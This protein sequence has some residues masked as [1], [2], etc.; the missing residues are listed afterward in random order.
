M[1]TPKSFR[2]DFADF[3][4]VR[5]RL[6]EAKEILRNMED[7]LKIWKDLVSLMCKR[8]GEQSP[9]ASNG[10]G[11][12]MQGMVIDALTREGRPIKS[13]D[14]HKM[15]VEEGHSDITLEN[16]SNA[17]WYAA[18]RLGTVRKVSRGVYAPLT[19]SASDRATRLRRERVD[20][21]A[22]GQHEDPDHSGA[23][24]HCGEVFD[25]E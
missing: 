14:L 19:D 15:L 17:L 5:A 22:R 25:D 6:P 7:E 4:D 11:K 18:E 16:V 24:I 20:R 23:C 12:R 3:E 1:E 21:C 2:V 9:T 10:Q 8:I 13:R